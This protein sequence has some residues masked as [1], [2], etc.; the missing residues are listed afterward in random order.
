MSNTLVVS[1]FEGNANLYDTLNLVLTSLIVIFAP[2][3]IIRIILTPFDF[4]LQRIK[5]RILED[6]ISIDKTYNDAFLINVCCSTTLGTWVKIVEGLM[7]CGSNKST[8][9]DRKITIKYF[10]YIIILFTLSASLMILDRTD[11]KLKKF[12]SVE[13][14]YGYVIIELITSLICISLRW[15]R[16][17]QRN[18]SLVKLI[19]NFENLGDSLAFYGSTVRQIM[20]IGS[21]KLK[22]KTNVYFTN[23]L[24]SLDISPEK[25]IEH[26]YKH[27]SIVGSMIRRLRQ[28]IN[29]EKGY[30]LLGF[31]NFP[32]INLLLFVL[33][34]IWDGLSMWFFGKYLVKLVGI[35]E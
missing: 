26:L 33:F 12:L 19:Q 9:I 34:I 31:V 23:C 24:E 32:G 15:I 28:C 6:L 21:G 13:H 30:S 29:R 3:P 14:I 27:I 2:Y 20:E 18:K 7:K 16:C 8:Y 35:N 10:F 1:I 22:G 25:K 11:Y 5:F 17:N 4:D